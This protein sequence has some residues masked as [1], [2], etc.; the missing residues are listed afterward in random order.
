M[1][2]ITDAILQ[3]LEIIESGGF[4][5]GLR[6]SCSSRRLGAADL[7]VAEFIRRLANLEKLASQDL[8]GAARGSWISVHLTVQE[9]VEAAKIMKALHEAKLGTFT[10]GELEPYAK[11]MI[12]AEQ[13]A[14]QESAA[15]RDE[16]ISKSTRAAV[17]RNTLRPLTESE[18]DELHELNGWLNEHSYYDLETRTLR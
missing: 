1:L 7:N 8:V 6:G 17:I 4:R 5:I 15:F 12:S 9:Q 11:L 18:A 2:A 13:R 3:T 16:W 14:N 10:D